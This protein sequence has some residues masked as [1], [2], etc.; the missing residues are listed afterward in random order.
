MRSPDS[1]LYFPMLYPMGYWNAQSYGLTVEDVFLTAADGTK[2][3]GWWVPGQEDAPTMLFFHANAGNITH[4][5]DNLMRWQKRGLN[6]F[7]LD[8]RGYGR[9]E[10]TPDEAGL[11]QDAEVAYAYVCETRGTDP[12]QTVLFGRSLGG[13][14][15]FYVASKLPVAGVIVESTF[16]SLSDLAALFFPGMDAHLLQGQYESLER[17][18]HVTMPLLVV[19]GT[20]DDLV[21]VEQGKRL[22]AAHPGRIGKQKQLYL[23]EDAGHNDTYYVGGEKYFE[24][25]ERF[26]RQVCSNS[27]KLASSSASEKTQI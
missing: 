5:I 1:N 26:I 10:G 27:W 9:S 19:H 22:F 11:Y 15:A 12:K 24:T 20:R 4:R 3:H 2:L 21:P 13:A 8:Y 6:T 7:I 18:Q 23:I 14:V 17:A 16:T 25:L